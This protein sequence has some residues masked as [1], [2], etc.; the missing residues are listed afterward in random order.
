M[1][2]RLSRPEDFAWQAAVVIVSHGECPESATEE[3]Q[4]GFDRVAE[5]DSAVA[6]WLAG[7]HAAQ[8]PGAEQGPRF[9]RLAAMP[10]PERRAWLGRY[11]ASRKSCTPS[12]V[13]VL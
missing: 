2:D 7:P 9:R 12:E 11:L 4:G 3:D 10:A 8:P 13:P 1:R 6:N 5:S